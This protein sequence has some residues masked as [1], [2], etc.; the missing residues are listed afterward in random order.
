M[1]MKY[2]NLLKDLDFKNQSY[3]KQANGKGDY[4]NRGQKENTGN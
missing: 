2:F 1:K 3:E 4:T